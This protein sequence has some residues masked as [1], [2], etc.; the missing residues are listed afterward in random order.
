[1]PIAATRKLGILLGGQESNKLKCSVLEAVREFN[2]RLACC[3]GMLIE[4]VVG[5]YFDE[6]LV[7]YGD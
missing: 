6:D 5:G 2:S 1:M 4:S 3:Y 7:N